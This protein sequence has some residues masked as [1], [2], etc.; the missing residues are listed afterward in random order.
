MSSYK[1]L[2]EKIHTCVNGRSGHRFITFLDKGDSVEIVTSR[3][4]YSEICICFSNQKKMYGEQLVPYIYDS[5]FDELLD[6]GELPKEKVEEQPVEYD[7]VNKPSHYNRE[8]AMECFDEFVEIYG[9]EAAR[10]ACMFNIHKY[11]YR[12]ADK[13]GMEDLKKSDWYARKLKELN[14]GRY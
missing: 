10:Y 8:G 14:D 13:N 9:V 1:E 12:A 11:R 2:L 7:V 6:Y 3:K 5:R 4:N